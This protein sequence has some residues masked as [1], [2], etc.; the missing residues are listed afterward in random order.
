MYFV[1]QGSPP[2]FRYVAMKDVEMKLEAYLA[3]LMGRRQE[4]AHCFRNVEHHTNNVVEAAFRIL[5]DVILNSTRAYNTSHLVEYVSFRM[6]RYYSRKFVDVANG[7]CDP[8]HR[9]RQPTSIKKVNMLDGDAEKQGGCLY[10]I[11]KLS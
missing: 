4:W 11:N 8:L 9:P 7:R 2:C 5:K 10:R 1:F 3:K 6:D